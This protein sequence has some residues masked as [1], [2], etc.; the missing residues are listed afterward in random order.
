MAV[1]VHVLTY[2]IVAH[3]VILIVFVSM[4][5]F[6]EDLVYVEGVE[7]HM[8]DVSKNVMTI[9]R[10]LA[11]DFLILLTSTDVHMWTTTKDVDV[12]DGMKPCVTD[13]E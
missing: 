8:V 9:G 13:K 2:A 7:F 5:C 10:I 6:R 4:N 3:R 12:L 11:V 1:A